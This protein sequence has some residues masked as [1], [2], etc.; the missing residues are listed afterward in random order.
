MKKKN[1]SYVDMPL[2]F[3]WDRYE[4]VNAPGPAHIKQ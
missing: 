2:F 1:A 3:V 4:N